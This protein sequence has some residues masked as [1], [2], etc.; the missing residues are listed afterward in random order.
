MPLRPPFLTFICATGLWAGAAMTAMAAD[1]TVFAASSLKTALDEVAQV[2]EAQTGLDVAISYAGSSVLA[3]QI[4]YG[5]PAD[6]FVSANVD[7]M[8]VLQNAGLLVAGSR[9]DLLGNDLVLVAFEDN[10]PVDLTDPADLPARLG[11]GYLAM[12]LV[13]AVPAGI[14]GKTALQ[15]LGLWDSVSG[16]VAQSDNVR[17]A[18]AL[19]ATGEAPFGVVYATDARAAAPVHVVA[20][21]PEDS[22][23]PII[24]PMAEITG[25]GGASTQALRAF[26]MAATTHEIFAAH[27]FTMLEATP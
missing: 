13:D 7:W 2:F 11:E 25:Q 23:P 1:V 20:T 12:A 10:T 22:H 15:A 5:A 18:L 6:L 17:A 9:A 3:R 8:D 19:V 4:Q 24:Y 21:F 27:G 26:L 16:Q 14:Y